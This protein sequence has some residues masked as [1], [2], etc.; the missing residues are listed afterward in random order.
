MDLVKRSS[1]EQREQMDGKAGYRAGEWERQQDSLEEFGNGGIAMGPVK[2]TADQV[3]RDQ[4]W[5]QLDKQ[6]WI[7]TGGKAFGQAGRETALLNGF[8]VQFQFMGC[9][10]AFD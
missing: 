9:L 7:W 4:M 5:R 1:E 3:S 6:E 2:E 8:L 10:Q